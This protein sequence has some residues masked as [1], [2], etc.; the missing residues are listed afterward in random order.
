MLLSTGRYSDSFFEK[1]TLSK[2]DYICRVS[3]K[4]SAFN[5]SEA[6]NVSLAKYFG[7]EF[8]SDRDYFKRELAP[9]YR[10]LFT[11]TARSTTKAEFVRALDTL[12]ELYGRFAS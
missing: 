3:S 4:C 12:M 2:V 10:L 5:S 6:E 11:A 1:D 8:D 9:K 7:D